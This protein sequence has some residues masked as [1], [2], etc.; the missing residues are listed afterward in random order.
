MST[1]ADDLPPLLETVVAVLVATSDGRLNPEV[2]RAWGLRILEDGETVSVGLDR[3]ASQ[4]TLE[5]LRIDNRVA[6]VGINLAMVARQ[7]KGRCI[8]IGKPTYEDAAAIAAHRELFLKTGT[9]YNIPEQVSRRYW[10]DDVV[11]LRCRIDE[12]FD[13]S[14]GPEAGRSL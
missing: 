14:P 6:L 1:L 3:A 7:L 11:S 5:N 12:V 13:Q 2:T 9:E 8:E 4:Q 10:S